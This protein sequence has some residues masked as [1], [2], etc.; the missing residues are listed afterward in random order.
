MA[1]MPLQDLG[2]LQ[3]GQTKTLF[4]ESHCTQPL[5]ELSPPANLPSM[6]VSPAGA[7]NF[8][9]VQALSPAGTYSVQVTGVA[10]G[11]C[12]IF[13]SAQSAPSA[14][15]FNA[16]Q[17]TI[18]VVADPNAPQPPDHFVFTPFA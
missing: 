10:I 12:I 1:R 2:P 4:F 15:N 3:V 5:D 17:A 9:S 11:Q 18:E 7:V 14:G 6:N 8:G 16:P 13:A